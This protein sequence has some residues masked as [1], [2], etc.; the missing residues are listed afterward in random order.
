MFFFLFEGTHMNEDVYD[1][2]FPDFF[3]RQISI[4]QNVNME[5]ILYNV[6]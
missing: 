3:L 5:Y 1:I 2:N 4:S 6:L